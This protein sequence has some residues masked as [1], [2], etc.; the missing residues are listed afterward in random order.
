MKK[1]FTVLFLTL[2]SA[3]FAQGEGQLYAPAPP[4]DAAFVRILNASD[5]EGNF[6]L[7]DKDFGAVAAASSS[8]YQVITQGSATLSGDATGTYD[9]AAGK[10]Y[11][12]VAASGKGT[13]IEDPQLTN[14]AQTLILLYNAS[15]APVNLKTADGATAVIPDVAPN[16]VGSVEVNPIAV[17]FAVFKGT[18]A[19]QAFDEVQLSRSAAYSAFV[20]PGG[21][22]VFSQNETAAGE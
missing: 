1:L 5:A 8:P 22:A 3:V 4:A 17:A 16:E 20:L 15:N 6:V 12:I 14:R 9:V 18:E 2:L 10:F 21:K 7:G 13:L 19:V 11:T